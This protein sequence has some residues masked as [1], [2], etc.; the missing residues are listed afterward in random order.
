MYPNLWAPD[1]ML[2]AETL[3]MFAAMVILLLAYRYWRQPSWRG[4]VLVGAA[5]AAARSPRSELIL[6]ILLLVVPLA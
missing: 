4:L 3:S 2:Q 6:L 5:C 1:G